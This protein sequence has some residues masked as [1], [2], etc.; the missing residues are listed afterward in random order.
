MDSRVAKLVVILL[1]S[2]L[3][4]FRA[5]IRRTP[6]QSGVAWLEDVDI[7]VIAHGGVSGYAPDKRLPAIE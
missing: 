2:I 5:L 6:T 7:A 1:A 4:T 3:I